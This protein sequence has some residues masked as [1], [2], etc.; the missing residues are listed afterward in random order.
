MLF[1][2]AKS[3]AGAVSAEFTLEEAMRLAG[4]DGDIQQVVAA[5]PRTGI[6][7]EEI[8]RR[9]QA[10]LPDDI[11]AVTGEQAAAELSSDVQEG[12]PFFS[13][14]ILVFGVIALL[15]GIFVIYNTFSIIV[16]QRTRELALLRAVGASRRQVLSAVIIEGVVVGLIGALLGLGVGI[17]L[18][19]GFISAIGDDFAS[20]VTITVTTTIRALLDR[21]R[22][23]ADRG[24]HPRRAGHAGPSAGRHA[25]RRHRPLRRVEDPHRHRARASGCSPTYLLAQGWIGDGTSAVQPPVFMGAGLLVLAAITVGPVLAGPSVRLRRPRRVDGE[26]HHREAGGGERRP[27]PEAHV[28]HRVRAADRRHPRRAAARVRRVRQ[29]L[30]RQGD[31]AWVRRRLRRDERRRRLRR[32][33]RL[34]ADDRRPGRRGAEAWTRWWPQTFAPAEITYDDGETVQQ[35]LTSI[36]VDSLDGVLEVRMEDGSMTDLDDDGILVDVELADAHDV[37]DRRLRSTCC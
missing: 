25:R 24:D 37:R 1:G 27:Q 7:Q 23:H 35:F 12:F 31:L 8:T 3:S 29:G 28:G 15:V 32:L 22:G 30:D 4:T 5:A 2:T 6:S 36:D 11:E 19:Q 10:A 14:I 18:A 13:T 26:W 16:Q 21:R 9:I 33:Q 34:L 17:L 20:G